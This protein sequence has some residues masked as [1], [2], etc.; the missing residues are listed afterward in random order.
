MTQSDQ[1]AIAAIVV[2]AISLL[3]A[4][5]AMLQ[6]RKA[7]KLM[8]IYRGDGAEHDAVAKQVVGHRGRTGYR[9]LRGRMAAHRA[10]Q[11]AGRQQAKQKIV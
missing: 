10:Q 4:V 1:I 7:R 9:G 3:I 8:T 6:V 11:Q 5:F 2:A